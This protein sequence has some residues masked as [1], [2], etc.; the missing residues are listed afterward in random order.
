[1]GSTSA[2]QVASTRDRIRAAAVQLYARKGFEATGI[3]EL[4]AAVN[5]TPAAIYNHVG[6]KL[7]ILE[8]IVTTGLR[9][10]THSGQA[11]VDRAGPEPML[12]LKSLVESHMH[13]QAGSPSTAKVIDHEFRALPGDRLNR[14]LAMR[15]AYE[16]LWTQV[17]E[18]GTQ[19]GVFETANIKLTRFALLEMCNGVAYWYKPDGQ[20]SLETITQHYASL[21]AAMVSP[22]RSR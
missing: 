16:R 12:Q 19:N 21:A 8:E 20:F 13:F 9:Q 17:L 15:D 6:A 14:V 10:L 1:M 22:H 18:S 11:A 3:R 2:V 4:A 5:I 7:D